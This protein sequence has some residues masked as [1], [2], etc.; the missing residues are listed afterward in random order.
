MKRIIVSVFAIVFSVA[1]VQAQ[2]I[3]ER[4]HDGVHQ[5]DGHKRHHGKEMADFNLTEDQKAKFKTL[6]EEQHK[7][8]ADLKKQDNITVKELREKMEDA[9]QRSPCKST[10]SSH[11]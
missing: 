9:S 4:K 2:E 1:A 8:M 7:Q 6:N 10:S 5:K 3:P 11:S